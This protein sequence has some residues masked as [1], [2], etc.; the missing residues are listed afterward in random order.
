MAASCLAALISSQSKE[1]LLWPDSLLPLLLKDKFE[2]EGRASFVQGD[3][4]TSIAVTP[5]RSGL[6]GDACV[7]PCRTARHHDSIDLTVDEVRIEVA[8][9]DFAVWKAH[10]KFQEFLSVFRDT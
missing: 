6:P 3:D 10:P 9:D 5:L 8:A 4:A 7:R 1:L 2:V